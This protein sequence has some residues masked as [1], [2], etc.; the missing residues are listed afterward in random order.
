V[1]LTTHAVSTLRICAPKPPVSH[2]SLE[3][4]AQSNWRSVLW[5]TYTENTT[6]FYIRS[7]LTVTSAE[8]YILQTL[9]AEAFLQHDAAL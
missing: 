6:L 8:E 5:K 1:K 2:T 7:E 3:S 4:D 9:K